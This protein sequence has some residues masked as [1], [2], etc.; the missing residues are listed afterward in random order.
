MKDEEF[1]EY[2]HVEMPDGYMKRKKI[3]KKITKKTKWLT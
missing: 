1:V 2:K 3:I